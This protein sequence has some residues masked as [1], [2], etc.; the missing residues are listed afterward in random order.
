[1]LQARKVAGSIPDEHWIFQLTNPSSRTTALGSAQPLTEMSTKNLPRGK[2]RSARK[3]DN[4]TAVCEPI[5]YEMW[6]P[7]CVTTLWVSTTCYRDNFTLI[8]I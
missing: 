8:Y 1:M 5:V 4:L 6:E 7:H 2:G 3:A